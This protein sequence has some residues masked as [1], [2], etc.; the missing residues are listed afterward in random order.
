MLSAT[1]T[2][3]QTFITTPAHERTFCAHVLWS[4]SGDSVPR[5]AQV[6][7][8]PG[9]N[10]CLELFCIQLLSPGEAHKPH[11]GSEAAKGSSTLCRSS[12]G[13]AQGRAE[14][15]EAGDQH[16]PEDECGEEG[17]AA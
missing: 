10:Q 2:I 6:Q 13:Q 7:L 11:L 15:T 14:G 1:A 9:Q 5:S 12:S 8:N 17:E 16:R 4:M 3:T